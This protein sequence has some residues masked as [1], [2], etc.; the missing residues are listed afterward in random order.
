MNLHTETTEL[1][2]TSLPTHVEKCAMRYEGLQERFEKVEQRLDT[3]EQKVEGIHEDIIK[4]NAAMARVMITTA[5]TIV[6]GM[7]STLVVILIG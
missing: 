4:G 3:I 7:L 1:E 5:G 2:S 6:A